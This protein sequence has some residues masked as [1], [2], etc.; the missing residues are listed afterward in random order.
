MPEIR[1][2]RNANII[3]FNMLFTGENNL[4]VYFVFASG[5]NIPERCQVTNTAYQ[6][7]GVAVYLEKAV[8]KGCVA[9]LN[10]NYHKQ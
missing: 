4:I 3:R 8:T 5:E 2:E 6:P 7:E 9:M 10:E 1:R